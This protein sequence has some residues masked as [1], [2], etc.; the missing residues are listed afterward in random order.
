M[1]SGS[2]ARRSLNISPNQPIGKQTIRCSKCIRDKKKCLRSDYESAC[3]RCSDMQIHCHIPTPVIHNSA[4]AYSHGTGQDWPNNLNATGDH[5][6]LYN[7]MFPIASPASVFQDG[8]TRQTGYT[9]QGG[10]SDQTFLI[11][12]VLYA[13]A[14]VVISRCKRD[15]E[16]HLDRL[17]PRPGSPR[18]SRNL[19]EDLQFYCPEHPHPEYI[20]TRFV[21]TAKDMVEMLAGCERLLQKRHHQHIYGTRA[22][23]LSHDVFDQVGLNFGIHLTAQLAGGIVWKCT[24]NIVFPQDE[25]FEPPAQRETLNDEVVGSSQ[26]YLIVT[27]LIQ[28]VLQHEFA[29]TKW[30]EKLQNGISP[31]QLAFWN[32]DLDNVKQLWTDSASRRMDIDVVG[33]K[34]S[35]VLIEYDHWKL[36][37]DL[38]LIEKQQTMKSQ[39]ISDAGQDFRG[40]CLLSIAATLGNSDNFTLLRDN[41]AMTFVGRHLL[42]FALVGGSQEVVE[43][44][45]RFPSMVKEPYAKELRKAIELDRPGLARCFFSSDYGTFT[46]GLDEIRKLARL[47]HNRRSEAMRQLSEEILRIADINTGPRE[48]LKSID[49]AEDDVNREQADS[50]TGEN[51][52]HQYQN[53][54]YT[55]TEIG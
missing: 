15:C 16:E 55:Y 49:Y 36:L 25:Q 24:K 10:Q 35:H 1:N 8:Y 19:S 29:N 37:K 26:D 27:K 22:I 11:L 41:E 6:N 13:T 40:M 43:R 23:S 54:P 20:A 45:V 32:Q 7:H 38:V 31:M 46:Y 42:N 33:R 21:T 28:K 5:S 34:L 2:P 30:A 4:L 12:G 47:A 14:N 50:R 48:T 53:M 52:N 3:K 18:Y 44:I 51:R 17:S 9:E 39:I